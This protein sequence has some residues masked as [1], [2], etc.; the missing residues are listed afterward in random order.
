MLKQQPTISTKQAENLIYDMAKYS[1]HNHSKLRNL[2]NANIKR[3]FEQNCGSWRTLVANTRIPNSSIPLIENLLG[4]DWTLEA[5]DTTSV[6]VLQ[7]GH[8]TAK[9]VGSGHISILDYHTK[10]VYALEA[11]AIAI[12]RGSYPDLLSCVTHGVASVEAYITNKA[13]LWNKSNNQSPFPIKEK[14]NLDEKL[15][16]W[17]FTMVGYK[18][19]QAGAVWNHFTDFRNLNNDQFKH[20]SVGSHGASYNEMVKL[21]NKFR[22]GI[23]ELLFRLHQRFKEPVPSKIIRGIYLPDVFNTK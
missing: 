21:I 12:K 7:Y 6:T 1:D 15:N 5:S 17:L 22:T 23:S 19:K 4:Y 10:F 11:R 8:E 3:W 13:S 9:L 2:S 14:S 16:N 18:M 20:N